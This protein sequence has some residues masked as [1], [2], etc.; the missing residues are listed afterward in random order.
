MSTKINTYQDLLVRQKGMYLVTSCYDLLKTL[1]EK[2]KFNLSSQIR[3]SAISI[4]SNIAEG[5]GRRLTKSFTHFL[6]IALGSLYELE[7]QI[8]I[9]KRIYG[10]DT[11]IIRKDT[12]QLKKMIYSLIQKLENRSGSVE[13]EQA[14]YVTSDL[15]LFTSH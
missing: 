11:S 14:T 13:E 4:P 15:L 5:Y 6:N 10:E 2:E 1:P 7:T 3:R 9:I 8:E 12:E